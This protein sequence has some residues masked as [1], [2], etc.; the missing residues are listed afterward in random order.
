MG[1]Q[2]SMCPLKNLQLVSVG[3][4]RI[5]SWLRTQENQCWSSTPSLV[6]RRRMLVG[7]PILDKMV[8]ATLFC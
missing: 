4:Q 2:N 3:H 8:V 5:H 1:C 6:T 7:G